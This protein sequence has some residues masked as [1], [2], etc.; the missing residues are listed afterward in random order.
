MYLAQFSELLQIAGLVESAAMVAIS[1]APVLAFSISTLAA[2]ESVGA[3]LRFDSVRTIACASAWRL[4]L[5]HPLL[6]D[7]SAGLIE[8][9][10]S[11]AALLARR[12]AAW[13]SFHVEVREPPDLQRKVMLYFR[14]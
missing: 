10:N 9:E 3:P 8:D 7:I 2:L 11:E 12:T 5:R 4:A 13:E 6:G 1:S 14:H